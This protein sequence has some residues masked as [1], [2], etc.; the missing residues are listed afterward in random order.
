MLFVVFKLEVFEDKISDNVR[1][2]FILSIAAVRVPAPA[3]SRNGNPVVGGMASVP[4]WTQIG[5]MCW[6][7]APTRGDFS[8]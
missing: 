4:K 5:G 6:T 1:T 2:R 7:A 3:L 8:L